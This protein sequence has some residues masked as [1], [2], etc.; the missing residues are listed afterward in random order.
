MSQSLSERIERL[1][2][3]SRKSLAQRLNRTRPSD[4]RTAFVAGVQRSGTNMV[5]DVLERSFETDVYH[6]YD[7]R[8]FSRYEMRERPVIRELVE[9]SPASMVII[10][11]LCELQELQDLLDDFAPSKAVWMF[12][13]YHDVINSHIA[14]WVGMPDS[15]AKIVQNRESAGW[16]GR[17]MSDATHAL[18]KDLYT[19]DM[20]NATACALFWYFRNLLFFERAYDEDPRILAV[21][22]DRLV[23]E[24]T[25]QFP[26]VFG[27]LELEY[28]KRV[29]SSVFASSVGKRLAPELDPRVHALCDELTEQIQA[30]VSD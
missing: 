5:M 2:V 21:H 17:G 12:R 29:S 7:S 18:V 23:T 3:V 15:I 22:Y 30:V 1:L 9:K 8:A 11:A 28:S 25:T 4:R 27:F 6:E 14:R 19:P 10:K 20:S 24:P 16:R 13:S 26:K